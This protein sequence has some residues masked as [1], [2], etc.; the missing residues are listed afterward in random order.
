MPH[1]FGS[2]ELVED[3]H[4]RELCIGCG[5]CVDLCP[6]FKNYKGKTAQLF[7][8]NLE[9]G[10]CFTYCPKAEV[11]LDDIYQRTWGV[12]YEGSALGPYQEIV[13]AKAGSIGADGSFQGGGSVSAL[14][15]HAM[16]TGTLDAAVLTDKDLLNTQPCLVTRWEEV[17]DSAGSRFMSAPTLSGLNQGVRDGHQKLGVVGTPCQTLAVAQMRSNS[18]SNPEHQVPVALSIGLFCNWS[19][20]SRQFT[21]LLGQKADIGTIR[22]MDIP[23]PPAKAMVLDTDAGSVEV[24]LS[25]IRPLIPQTCFTC[26]DLT[27][28]LAD[29]SVGMYEGR[30]GWNTLII[31]SEKGAHQVAEA[32]KDGFLQTEAMPEDIIHHLSK[33]AL[34]K[35]ERS[36]RILIQREL[37]NT[38]KGRRASVRIP[39]AVMKKILPER[40]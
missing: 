36:L 31:R 19:L 3:V 33:A 2:K 9:Q 16:K 6:Y 28:E 40:T 27:S 18:L 26:L 34:A 32:V 23:P 24:S 39:P 4:Q 35:K 1:V 17:L 38:A 37:I 14:M 13:A 10:R 21:A 29:V 8:C 30:P 12:P 20:D 15:A 25:D 5:A 11:D 22:S 7:P